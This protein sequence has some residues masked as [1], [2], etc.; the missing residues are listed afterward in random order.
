MVLGVV[1]VQPLGIVFVRLLEVG[2]DL[3]D[4]LDG[5]HLLALGDLSFSLEDKP[6]F[7][8]VVALVQ[9]ELVLPPVVGVV[10]VVSL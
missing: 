10:G 5:A 9:S 3:E 7:G 1:G 6:S 8:E 2:E 4:V